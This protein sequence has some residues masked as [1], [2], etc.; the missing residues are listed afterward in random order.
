MSVIRDCRAS[1][2]TATTTATTCTS[3]DTRQREEENGE[4]LEDSHSFVL[5]ALTYLGLLMLQYGPFRRSHNPIL[6]LQL[7]EILYIELSG[8][9]VWA[10]MGFL[11]GLGFGF[12]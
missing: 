4:G 12:F 8:A 7:V 3:A 10:G 11:V 6:Y 1:R 2:P 5:L 9:M